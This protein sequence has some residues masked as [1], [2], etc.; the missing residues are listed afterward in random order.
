MRQFLTAAALLA[1]TAGGAIAAMPIMTGDSSSGP[2]LTDAHGM[3]L[4]TYDPDTAE[5][6]A[7]NGKCAE[8][9]PPL[10]AS[11]DDKAEG[12][13]NI[14]TRDDGSLQWAYDGHPLYLWIK[15]KAPGDI[16]GDGVKGVWHL[17]R[18]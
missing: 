14:I 1:L 18:P 16:T 8:N 12:E 9:W 15:D 5:T 3:T 11:A 6:S 2:V 7:C 13:Y 17:A 4:Y 10:L